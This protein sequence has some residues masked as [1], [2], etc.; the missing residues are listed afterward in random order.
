MNKNILKKAKIYLSRL[1][2][3]NITN[4]KE[5][6]EGRNSNVFRFRS[7]KRDLILKIYKHKSNSRINN[8]P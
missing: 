3:N 2:F 5:I 4:L 1:D 8:K 6:K 7:N